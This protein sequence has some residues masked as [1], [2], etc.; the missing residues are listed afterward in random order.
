VQDAAAHSSAKQ[1]APENSNLSVRVLSPG[2]GGS[3]TQSNSAASSAASH[4]VA[5]TTQTVNQTGSGTTCGCH[6]AGTGVQSAT[7]DASTAQGA[8]AASSAE[9]IHP[10]N[11]ND[12]IRVGSYGNDGSVVQS[13]DA[14]S[15]ADAANLA[16]TTQG[17]SQT[18]SGGGVQSSTQDAT[19][20]QD[21]AALSSATQIAPENSNLS[22]RV[23]SPGNGGS[24]TQSN[25]AASTASSQNSASPTQATTQTAAA[26]TCGCSGGGATVQAA[27][28]SSSVEQAGIAASLAEQIHASN[29]SNPIR[30]GSDGNDGALTQAN[31]AASSA[32]AANTAP[33]TQSATQMQSGGCGCGGAGV[34]ALGQDSRVSQL[35]VGLSA[36]AQIGASNE[37]GPI[38]VGSNGNGGSLTQ[39]NTAASSAGASNTA[40]P[41]Q[42]ATQTQ[43]GSGVQALGQSSNVDQAA[44]AAS[45]ALQLPGHSECG[46]GGTSSGN[47][48]G[49]I[50]I[51]SDG[52]DGNVVQSNTAMSA[53]GSS[54][55]AGTTQNGTQT[56]AGGCGCTGLGVQA[57]GQYATV[58]QLAAAL[59]AAKQ[60]GAANTIA[61]VR[62]HSGGGG[63]T[64][65]QANNAASAAAAPNASRI[66]QAG[67]QAMV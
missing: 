7:Q 35:A 46:C 56:Q 20:T 47:S 19:T 48:S 16:T 28:Q 14:A 2:N 11:Q 10:S 22:V 58:D 66:L 44:L 3:V 64:T 6:S 38:R 17:S 53:A 55:S 21:A 32:Q 65:S 12:P 59:S 24:V 57:L 49:P 29:E 27:G 26:P 52:N 45:H 51:W 40:T 31:N 13:N 5:P 61:P 23:L 25:N 43:S 15:R 37:S 54:N 30:I 63:G 4:N 1:I 33:V 9:Q 41:A 34:Q 8:V 67:M 36:A 39:S 42:S 60:I 50:R 18:G 62:V